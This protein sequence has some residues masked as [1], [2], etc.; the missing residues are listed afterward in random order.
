MN[1]YH[2]RV[3]GT[4]VVMLVIFVGFMFFYALGEWDQQAIAIKA[5]VAEYYVTSTGLT[6]FRYFTEQRH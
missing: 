5:K 6:G 4:F 1:E 3:G 2:Y